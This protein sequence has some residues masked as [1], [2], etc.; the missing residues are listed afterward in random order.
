MVRRLDDLGMASRSHTEA[1]ALLACRMEEVERFDKMLNNSVDEKTG[2][3]VNGYVYK[4]TNS[5][6]DDILKEH[7]AVRLREK[8]A[9]HVHSLLTEF[10]LTPAAAQKVGTPK[11]K[12]KK[13]EFEGF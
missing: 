13:N 5:Y 7:P 4:T 10:G 1:I 11:K 12:E 8:A 3:K 9:R 2:E 6:G